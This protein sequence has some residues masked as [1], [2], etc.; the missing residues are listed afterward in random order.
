MNISHTKNFIISLIVYPYDVMVSIGETDKQLKKRL[1]YYDIH[2][3]KTWKYSSPNKCA[4]SAIFMGDQCLIRIKG[5]P[6]TAVDFGNLQ[7]E[8]FHVVTLVMQRIGMDL[9]IKVSDEAY[10]YLIGY[11]T[12]EVYEKIL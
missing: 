7:H 8:I 11:L 6:T 5:N 1:A 12:K 10:A 3:D 4:K 2:D 9:K